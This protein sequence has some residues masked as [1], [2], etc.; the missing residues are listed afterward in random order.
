MSPR[1]ERKRARADA[2]HARRVSRRS[3]LKG[4]GAAAVGIAASL[5]FPR[6]V[7][8]I[9]KPL[10]H[11]TWDLLLDHVGANRYPTTNGPEDWFGPTPDTGLRH[12]VHGLVLHPTRPQRALLLTGPEASGK[13]LFHDAMGLLLPKGGV[14]QS[15]AD[16][17]CPADDAEDFGWAEWH[18]RLRLDIEGRSE[19]DRRLKGAWLVVIDDVPALHLGL[20]E[21]PRYRDGRFLKW[22][23]MH[24]KVVRPLPNVAHFDVRPP[25]IVIP[26]SDLI[27]RLEDERDA[28]QVTL[29][30]FAA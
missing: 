30:R 28:F 8:A 3:L 15:P 19:R 14:V 13:M 29:Q 21:V 24:D 2:R 22:S 20:F 7:H 4:A 16:L 6:M 26:K 23:L 25:A 10:P 18:K 5:F 11:P 9:P 17:R 1:V 27:R 12:W